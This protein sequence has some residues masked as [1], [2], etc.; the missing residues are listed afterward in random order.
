MSVIEVHSE[1][2]FAKIQAEKSVLFFWAAWH[3]PSKRGGQMQDIYSTLAQKYNN[4]KF[5]LIEAEVVPGLSEQFEITV[6][7]TFLARVGSVKVETLEGANPPDLSNMVK[8]LNALT[9]D[10]VQSLGADQAQ[11][12]KKVLF[13]KLEKLV[14]AAPI[15]LFMKGNASQPRCGFSRQMIEILQNDKIP[16]ASFDILSDEEVRQG[17]KEYSEWPTFPQLYVN[18][19]LIGGLDIVKE[20]VASGNFREQL[21]VDQMMD[22]LKTEDASKEEKKE[23][24]KEA[25]AERLKKLI[26]TAPVM[27]FMKG[28]ATQPRCGFSSQ[29]VEILKTENLEFGS[30]DILS[31]EEVRQA[32]KEFS[33][34][35]TY[36]QLYA[37]GTFV[38]GLDI[39]KEM[40]Q[41]GNF[42]EQIGLN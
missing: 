9:A 16:F 20:M 17:L 24:S 6:V 26:N 13:Q 41:G 38:G 33:D 34:W 36:P 31:D 27:L 15:M 39:V 22:K 11:D 19:T 30:F 1:E 10:Q 4:I 25:M 37:N 7:P 28:N 23:N 3:Q 12:P 40:V 42:K 35:P 29:M 8:K 18:G 2:E 14:N 5:I 21:G 32:L